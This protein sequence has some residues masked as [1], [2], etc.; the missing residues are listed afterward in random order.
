MNP[1]PQSIPCMLAT[2]RAPPPSR[3][4][5]RSF[6]AERK[7]L[8]TST[9]LQAGCLTQFSPVHPRS[10]LESA[11]RKFFFFVVSSGMAMLQ[12]G[13]MPLLTSRSDAARVAVGFSPRWG[14]CLAMRRG[15]TLAS[16]DAWL[17]FLRRCATPPSDGDHPWAEAHGYHHP[18]APR[19]APGAS[20]VFHS[21]QQGA[22]VAGSPPG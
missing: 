11:M 10:I 8:P 21:E 6:P 15:A 18:I 12:S 4:F 17:C 1:R 14:T 2:A 5:G 16:A 19:L 9:P 20:N 3:S 7:K 13:L 22:A